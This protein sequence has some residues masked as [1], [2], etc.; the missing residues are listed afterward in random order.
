MNHNL[1][2]MRTVP[3]D[4]CVTR[5]SCNVCE[6]RNCNMCIANLRILYTLFKL[7]AHCTVELI[8]GFLAVL[9][10]IIFVQL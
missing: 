2:T 7:D 6:F 5:S 4:F 1:D 8:R 9:C 10:N 3:F